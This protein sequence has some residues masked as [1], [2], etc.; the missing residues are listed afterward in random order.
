[1]RSRSAS[2][3]R[4]TASWFCDGKLNLLMRT[5]LTS[6]PKLSLTR[7]AV[8]APISVTMSSMSR[9]CGSTDTSAVRSLFPRMVPI[10]ERITSCSRAS[11]PLASL[12]LTRKRSG[13]ATDQT[14]KA[15]TRM[16]FLSRVRYS[17]GAASSTLTRLSMR[18]RAVSMGYGSLK[19]RPA[20]STTQ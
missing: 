16:F 20:S 19:C 12:T 15:S 4:N 13:S 14:A 9:D 11:A 7:A 3:R 6:I 5:A 17:A 2:M 8:L 10:S 18:I 1:M